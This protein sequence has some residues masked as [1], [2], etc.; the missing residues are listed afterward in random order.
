V[1]GGARA[2]PASAVVAVVGRIAPY[3]WGRHRRHTPWSIPGRIWRRSLVRLER[4]AAGKPLILFAPDET[5]RA[6]IDMYART[7]RGLDTPG[8]STPPSIKHL[9]ADAAA[10]PAKASSS[11]CL[12]GRAG[13]IAQRLRFGGQAR[14]LR[15][16]GSDGQ[17]ELP[18]AAVGRIAPGEE[19]CTAQRPP[20]RAARTEFPIRGRSS[21]SDGQ[22]SSRPPIGFAK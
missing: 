8:R 19:L 17:P 22:K 1:G 4:D 2:G 14:A 21:A 9:R 5:T 11:C 10:A 3:S 20:L 12:P 18:L 13:S 7:T 15:R 6:I 16:S